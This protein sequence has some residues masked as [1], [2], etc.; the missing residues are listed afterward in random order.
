MSYRHGFIIHELPKTTNAQSSMHWRAKMKYVRY[1]HEMV[2][3]VRKI[4]PAPLLRAKLTLT[5]FSSS[6]PDFDGLVSSFKPVIDGLVVAGVLVNDKMSNIGQS[7]YQWEKCK[8]KEGR[9]HVLI[10]GLDG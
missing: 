6:E 5:R 8:R 2:W 9:I 7:V 1:W 10:E 3:M 4:P